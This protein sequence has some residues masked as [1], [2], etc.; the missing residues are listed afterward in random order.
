MLDNIKSTYFSLILFSFIDEGQKLKLIKYSKKMQKFLNISIIHYQHFKGKYIIYEQYG[1]AKE[2][3]GFNNRIAF[4]GEYLNGQRNGKGKEYY[5]NG[6]LE[7][8]GEYLKGKRNGKGKEYNCHHLI[9]E[10]DYSMDKEMEK[11][12]NI[13]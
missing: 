4:E 6:E 10:G 2:Y 3:F 7:F 9:F 1:K 11:E 8:E 13:I 5:E 12:K